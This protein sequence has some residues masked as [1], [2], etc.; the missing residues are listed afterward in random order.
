MVS[1]ENNNNDTHIKNV[2]AKDC[3]ISLLKD[4]DDVDTQ[5][6]CLLTS[7]EQVNLENQNDAS[8]TILSNKENLPT[9]KSTDGNS[10]HHLNEVNDEQF[11]QFSSGT[12]PPFSQS[13]NSICF[14]QS[15]SPE[16]NK[17]N[18]FSNSLYGN[19]NFG[20]WKYSCRE[21]FKF[22]NRYHIGDTLSI[23]SRKKTQMELRKHGIDCITIGIFGE[24]GAGKS[25]FFNS[26]YYVMSGK[27]T[28]YSAERK[29]KLLDKN[30]SV[31]D[32]RLELKITEAITV[33]DN[34]GNSF[35]PYSLNELSKQC[36]EFVLL[37]YIN[38]S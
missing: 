25:A 19:P 10:L 20:N 12:L 13:Y 24:P 27:Y 5:L 32:R 15:N 34:R 26:V 8:L 2:E 37:F 36:G 14:H 1:D 23:V 16:S 29:I 28:E 18:R 3:H 33:L 9:S 31:T 6:N 35:F 11:S 17:S 30:H 21:Y 7:D 4:V 38:F 22:I